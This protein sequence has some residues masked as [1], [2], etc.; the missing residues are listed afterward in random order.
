MW[1]T[2]EGST[3]RLIQ[4]CIGYFVFYVVTGVS[5]KYFLGSPEHGLPGMDG[6]E[7]LVYSTAGGS[8]LA[9]LVVLV[10]RWYR[11]ESIRT[12]TVGGVRF[13]S[14]YAYII[15]SGVC[16]AVVIP[17]TTLMYT[18]PISVMVAM[19]I[20]RG[21]VIVISRV[22]DSIQIRQGL[23]DKKV[24]AEENIAVVFAIA[25]VAVHMLFTTEGGFDFLHSTPALAILGSYIVAYS[26]RIYIMNY[27]KNTHARKHKQDNKAFF[28]VEQISAS[29]TL[30]LAT[31]LVFHSPGLFGWSGEPLEAF[32]GAFT[33]PRAVWPWAMLSGTAFGAV[34][35]FSVFLFMFKGRTATFAGLVNR[36][37]SLL[38]GTA[39]TVIFSV[40]FGG[41]SPR[42]RDWISLAFILVAI[43]FLTRSERR[44]VA[45]LDNM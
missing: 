23:L 34:A 36:L 40:G 10:L 39:A 33:A 13:P 41:S 12:V 28:G 5:V 26:F 21:S 11:L 31:V 45:E 18:L 43:G 20:M 15:P 2:M 35:F 29:I 38:A 27:Y 44:R 1:R 9:I 42:S 3:G 6:T 25:A 24:Y 8:A 17:T 22:V 37:T 4:L 16:T 32:R 19:V 7:Y 30:V 14:E